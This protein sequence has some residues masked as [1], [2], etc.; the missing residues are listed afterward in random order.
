[1]SGQ[2]WWQPGDGR[3]LRRDRVPM[4]MRLLGRMIPIVPL[5]VGDTHPN[6]LPLAELN[7]ALQRALATVRAECPTLTADLMLTSGHY[8]ELA[9]LPFGGL[10]RELLEPGLYII[11]DAG[12]EQRVLYVGSACDST[13]RSRLISHLFNDRRL[14]SAQ[15]GLRQTFQRWQVEGFP[16]T[17]QADA[18]LRQIVWGRNRWL[19]RPE[20]LGGSRLLAAEL[21]ATGA[22]DVATVRL[23]EQWSVV[24]RCL[25][26][27]SAEYVRA[28]MGWFPPLN[29]ARVTFDPRLNSGVVT[30]ASAEHLFH[31]LDRL[32][33]EW[34]A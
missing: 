9:T 17:M 4:D 14:H 5:R 18:D 12:P 21:V 26:R 29:D 3:S 24:A 11:T 32:A 1:M 28:A 25:E 34:A 22:F 23:P 31:T 30:R 20:L 33:R 6:W 15:N 16:D 8:P 7:R 2:Y 27:F 19:A 13:V 10:R